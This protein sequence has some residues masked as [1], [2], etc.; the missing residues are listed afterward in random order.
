MLQCTNGVGIQSAAIT[1]LLATHSVFNNKIPDWSNCTLRL[2]SFRA[3]CA[4]NLGVCMEWGY[5]LLS[6]RFCYPTVYIKKSPT[7]LILP[8]SLSSWQL[9]VLPALVYTQSGSTDLCHVD[10]V[11]HT[12]R[13]ST[14]GQLEPF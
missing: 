7:D 14:P 6:H 8:Q 13:Q 11:N 4:S 9:S 2:I 3:L 12:Q 5:G 1:M 10:A